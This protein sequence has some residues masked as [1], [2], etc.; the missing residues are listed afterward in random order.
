MSRDH[1]IARRVISVPATRVVPWTGLAAQK[2]KIRR[3]LRGPPS[4]Q[5]AAVIPRPSRVQAAPAELDSRVES[6]RDQGEPLP[7][8]QRKFFEPRFG[9]AFDGVRVHTT[10]DAGVLATA[11]G[12]KAFA[13]GR[14]VVF[15]PGY[16]QPTTSAGRRLMAHE[17]VHVV[18]QEHTTR[19][20]MRVA[21][22]SA[23]I[24]PAQ[25]S[26]ST[27]IQRQRDDSRPCGGR[28][29]RSCRDPNHHET[30]VSAASGVPRLLQAGLDLLMNVQ[31]DPTFVEDL[32]RRH[33][34]WN[35]RDPVRDRAA[36]A[37]QRQLERV[38]DNLEHPF[39]P[40]CRTQEEA[41]GRHVYAS[42][43]PA[44]APSNCYDFFPLFFDDGR[45]ESVPGGRA[46]IVLHEMCHRWITDCLT[47]TAEI[48]EGDSAY[49]PQW[50]RAI[51][52]A[53]SYAG[54]CHDAT[55]APL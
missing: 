16:Y 40:I 48:Y 45:V 39:I 51:A 6:L 2:S 55:R 22:Q 30:A 8:E 23:E 10:G 54:F 21:L 33:F 47:T 31:R 9:R 38:V 28:D 15:A 32:L 17:L 43:P 27:L 41:R 4:L 20:A 35:G 24:R 5:R 53:D 3:I 25:Q 36:T 7:V 42:A 29:V 11:L 49:P 26:S 37:I 18:Q 50:R 46:R 13:V 1:H 34:G 44:Y 14:H 12:A 52:N 19:T